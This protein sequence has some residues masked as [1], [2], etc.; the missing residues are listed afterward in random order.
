MQNR[1][2]GWLKKCNTI[3]K[4][5][6]KMFI[7]ITFS[8]QLVNATVVSMQLLFHYS[9]KN[10]FYIP[11]LENNFRRIYISL[12]ASNFD[13]KAFIIMK[14]FIKLIWYSQMKWIVYRVTFCYRFITD[15]VQKIYLPFDEAPV[16]F[17]CNLVKF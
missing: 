4:K 7:F 1:I 12:N 3:R 6:Y 9:F 11:S 2:I 13:S 14:I 17:L 15:R 8:L 16:L 5:V 10:C